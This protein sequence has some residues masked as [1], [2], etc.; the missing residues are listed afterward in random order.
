MDRSVFRPGIQ[1]VLVNSVMDALT[2]HLGVNRSELTVAGFVTVLHKGTSGNYLW[3]SDAAQPTIVLSQTASHSPVTVRTDSTEPDLDLSMDTNSPPDTILTPSTSNASSSVSSPTGMVE[4]EEEE[5][6][7]TLS[8]PLHTDVG[9]LSP[10]QPTTSQATSISQQLEPISQ[11]HPPRCQTSPEHHCVESER[12]LASPPQQPTT[13]C[14]TRSTKDVS[15]TRINTL[16]HP[17]NGDNLSLTADNG[18][19]SWPNQYPTPLKQSI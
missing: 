10:P 4:Q 15:F 16:T 14:S 3:R 17:F 18:L 6:E 12:L 9:S 8:R 11:T 5:K 13:P 7:T 2:G 19:S 1:Q